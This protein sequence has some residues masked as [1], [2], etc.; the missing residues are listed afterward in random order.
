LTRVAIR[1][2]VSGVLTL[3]VVSLLVFGATLAL[4]GDAATAILGREATPARLTELRQKLHLDESAV[5]QYGHW[6]AGVVTLNPGD[7]VVSQTPVTTVLDPRITNSL[8]LMLVAAVVGV[9]LAIALGVLMAVRRDSVVDH[10]LSS[11]TLV[12]ASLPPF[13]I[14]VLA[15]VLLSTQ[16]FKLLPA[17]SLVPAGTSVWDQPNV[18]VLPALTLCL[19][20]VPFVSRVMRGSMVEVLDSEYVTM[21]RLKGLSERRVIWHHAVP[22]AIGPAIHAT[23]LALAYM[24][25]GIVVVEFVFNYPGVGTA[26]VDA[27]QNRD[28]PVVEFTVMLIAGVY[29]VLNLVADLATTLVTPKLR[30]AER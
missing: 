8:W 9:P 3:W 10:G 18:L 19:V 14:G 12:F 26:L 17:V 2:I 13:V 23:A 7:S 27:V 5:A 15:I 4:P 11:G 1:R 25:G 22:N 6:L 20:I 29:V 24:A 16:V 28:M 30:T 21:A